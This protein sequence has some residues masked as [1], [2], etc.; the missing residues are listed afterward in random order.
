ML[1]IFKTVLLLSGF[2]LIQTQINAQDSI[3]LIKGLIVDKSNETPISYA[4]IGIPELSI[5][6]LSDE[7]GEFFLK[8][9][10]KSINT[11]LMVSCLG[12]FSEKKDLSDLAK[13][14]KN[15]RIAMKQAS[16]ELSGVEIL[17]KKITEKVKGNETTSKSMVFSINSV[18]I[19]AELGAVVHLPCKEVFL[20]DFNFN[21][22]SNNADSAL[23]RLKIYTYNDTIGM[24]L[25][26]KDIFFKIKKNMKGPFK[27]DLIKHNIIVSCNIFVSVELVDLFNIEAYS[28]QTSERDIYLNNRINISGTIL[29]SKS[30]HRKN[31]FFTW[32]K[33]GYSMSPGF[34]LTVAY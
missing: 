5:G 25:L 27:L 15:I 28:R 18:S 1:N 8:I 9:P 3:I 14:N 33:V 22:V 17:S 31:N 13:E 11:V 30:Y 23:F 16:I 19:G 12:Y 34:W 26:Q 29:G 4:S 20:K 6:T 10:S 7:K 2:L 21:I 32:E 24:S